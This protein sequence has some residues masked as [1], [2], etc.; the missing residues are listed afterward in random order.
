MG[1]ARHIRLAGFD[2]AEKLDKMNEQLN[3]LFFTIQYAIIDMD[4]DDG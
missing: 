4:N 3:N 1:K 2:F